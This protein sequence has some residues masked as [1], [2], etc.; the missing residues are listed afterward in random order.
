MS[1]ILILRDKQYELKAGITARRALEEI[2]V[3]RESVLIT[4]EGALITEDEI[5]REGEVIK[6]ISVISG[7]SKGQELA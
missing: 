2:G 3:P 4:R 5:L 1:V 7:G 6:L